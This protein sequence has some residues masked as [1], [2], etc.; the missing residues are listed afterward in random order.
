MDLFKASRISTCAFIIA[1]AALFLHQV[2]S[3]AETRQEK[4]STQMKVSKKSPGSPQKTI[5]SCA[6]LKVKLKVVKNSSGLV[7]L[8]GTVSNI[9]N[10]DY[11]IPSEARV[12]MNLKYP[13]KT[14]DQVGVSDLL[15]TKAFTKLN[16]DATFSFSCSYQIPNFDRWA[17]PMVTSSTRRL[18]TLSVVKNDMSSFKTGEDCNEKNNSRKVEV[19][20]QEK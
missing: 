2:T 5:E 14:Y 4:P 9:G 8:N 17:D 19:I 11:D 12:I 1:F 16:Q 18:F 7:T 6:D 13:P 10:A 15:C 20:Y 3:H